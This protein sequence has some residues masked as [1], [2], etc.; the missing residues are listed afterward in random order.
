MW[1][2]IIAFVVGFLVSGAAW[3]AITYFSERRQSEQIG[4]LVEQLWFG[5]ERE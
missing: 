3:L 5:D 1:G 2:L 4:T